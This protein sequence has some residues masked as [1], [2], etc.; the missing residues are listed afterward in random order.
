MTV[1]ASAGVSSVASAAGVLVARTLGLNEAT[2]RSAAYRLRERFRELFRQEIAK[3]VDQ[4]EEVEVE[5]KYL[6]RVLGGSVS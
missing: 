5:I 4:P 2:V 3:T 1:T 6:F